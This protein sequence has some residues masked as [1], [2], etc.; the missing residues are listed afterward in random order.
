MKTRVLERYT[1]QRPG[2]GAPVHYPGGSA[3]FDERSGK[4]RNVEG[5]SSIPQFPAFQ[6]EFKPIHTLPAI[7]GG[8]VDWT[9]LRVSPKT[10]FLEQRLSDVR[11]MNNPVGALGSMLRL[12]EPNGNNIQIN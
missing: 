7:V 4:Y 10:K 12:A 6:R 11:P 1:S 8:N 3:N 2:F 5:G 9:K